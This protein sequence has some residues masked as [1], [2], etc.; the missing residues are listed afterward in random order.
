VTGFRA[1]ASGRALVRTQGTP[2]II[3]LLELSLRVPLGEHIVTAVWINSRFEVL[4]FAIR[5]LHTASEQ[6]D[7]K[8]APAGMLLQRVDSVGVS[9]TH[10]LSARLHTNTAAIR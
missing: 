8:V 10:M 3:H 5:S 9:G 1:S 2:H 6:T 7:A 4:R